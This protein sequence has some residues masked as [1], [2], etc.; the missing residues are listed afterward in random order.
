MSKAFLLV[1]EEF[2]KNGDNPFGFGNLQYT[3]NVEESKALNEKTGPAIIIAASGMCEHGRILH[4]LKNNIEDDKNAIMI[5]GYQASYTLGRKLV[6][7]E[8]MVKIFGDEHNVGASVYVMDAFSGHADRS[9]L[10]DYIQNIDGLKKIFL[11]H[12]EETQLTSFKEALTQNGFGDIH[13]P[14]PDEEFDI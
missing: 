11:V 4:H 5:V 14:I 10:L 8:K 13:I 2:I 12:G 3:R 1:K 7:G 6:D 9:D